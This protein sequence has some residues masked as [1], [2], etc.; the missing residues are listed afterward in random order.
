MAWN[1]NPSRVSDAQNPASLQFADVVNSED[2]FTVFLNRLQI[3]SVCHPGT[4]L[5]V[6][7]GPGN[8]PYCRFFFPQPL[9]DD[10]VVTKN[11]NHKS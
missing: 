10:L 9:F 5:W 4:C 8:I 11:I 6:K 7:K 1:L 2:Q 3:Y